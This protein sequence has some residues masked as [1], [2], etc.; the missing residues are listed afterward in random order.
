LL[1]WLQAPAVRTGGWVANR[2]A[3][4]QLAFNAIKWPRATAG[5]TVFERT[6]ESVAYLL[7]CPVTPMEFYSVEKDSTV[8][9][10]FILAHAP[11]Q[12]RIV[13]F[14]A[15]SEDR[16]RWRTVIQVAV[17][18]AKSNRVAAEVVAVGSDPVTRQALADC[19]FHARGTSMLRILSGTRTELDEG[20]IRFQMIDSD[21]AYLHENK[22]DY[23]G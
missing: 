6:P 9:G 13:D 22:N 5:T 11:G 17:S 7:K 20:A 18:Q 23:W 16:E 3:P 1:W 19:G 4:E 15:D 14:C 12:V 10:Y 2:V 8:C 21:A